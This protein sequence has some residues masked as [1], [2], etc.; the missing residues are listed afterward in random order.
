MQNETTKESN[1]ALV[2]NSDIAN[3]DNDRCVAAKQNIETLNTFKVIQY[4][5]DQGEVKILSDAQKKDQV[6]LTQKQIEIYC[7]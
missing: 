7:K 6:A 3:Q 1:N 4:T 5:N 2:S